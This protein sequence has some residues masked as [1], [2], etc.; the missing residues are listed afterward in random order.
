MLLI[1]TKSVM[2]AI[3]YLLLSA[4]SS[5]P[6][7]Y[8]FPKN[9][10]PDKNPLKG[11]NSGWWLEDRNESSVGFQYIPWR[12]FEENNDNFDKTIN[13]VESIIERPGSE[14]RYTGCPEWMYEN[15]GVEHI[16]GMDRGVKNH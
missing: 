8:Q 14:D 4:D 12:R 13:V 11:W 7:G 16:T 1:N 6:I 15:V 10:G 9:E 3:T 5:L 2:P